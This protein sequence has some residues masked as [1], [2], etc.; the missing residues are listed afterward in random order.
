MLP[1]EPRHECAVE[2][3]ASPAD[4]AD[5]WVHFS[6]KA[7]VFDRHVAETGIYRTP[8]SRD[9]PDRAVLLELPQSR[10]AGDD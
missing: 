5:P 6:E 3:A 2:A 10:R 8:L 1:T 9:T 4:G 7:A